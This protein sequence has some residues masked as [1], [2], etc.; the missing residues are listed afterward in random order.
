MYFAC[1]GCP[2]ASGNGTGVAPEDGAGVPFCLSK[3][4]VDPVI[5]ALWNAKPIPLGRI[6]NICQFFK[7]IDSI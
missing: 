2:V 7:T 1:P 5:G 4:N 6:Y 3:S